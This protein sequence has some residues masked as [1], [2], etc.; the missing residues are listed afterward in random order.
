MRIIENYLNT[1]KTYGFSQ[2]FNTKVFYQE[3]EI[4][5]DNTRVK[6]IHM[7]NKNEE[8]MYPFEMEGL[9]QFVRV[10]WGDDNITRLEKDEIVNSGRY[11]KNGMTIEHT[12]RSA[13]TYRL[14][15]ESVEDLVAVDYNYDYDGNISNS[16]CDNIRLITRKIGGV[17]NTYT[18]PSSE[19]LNKFE[20]D[21]DTITDN[22]IKNN[23]VVNYANSSYCY[24]KNNKDYL[25]PS[26]WCLT[27]QKFDAGMI[28]DLNFRYQLSSNLS[29]F[30]S[31]WNA[32]WEDGNSDNVVVTH[33]ENTLYNIFKYKRYELNLMGFFAHTKGFYHILDGGSI[34]YFV[35]K[36][37][38]DINDYTEYQGSL[39]TNLKFIM[40]DFYEKDDGVK[41]WKIFNG[42]LKYLKL[43]K[44]I[45]KYPDIIKGA[46]GLINNLPYQKYFSFL[47][48]KSRLD[49]KDINSDYIISNPVGKYSLDLSYLFFISS[50]KIQG[51]YNLDEYLI[52]ND[53]CETINLNY[54]KM[55]MGNTFSDNRVAS[56]PIRESIVNS[57][58]ET[59][60]S[61][62]TFLP[63]PSFNN[64][65]EG[66]IKNV[67]IN[68]SKMCY[69]A[70]NQVKMFS[71]NS[72]YSYIMNGYSYLFFSI[73]NNNFLINDL[74][75]IKDSYY[76]IDLSYA[77]FTPNCNYTHG[78]T[79]NTEN[80]KYVIMGLYSNT[81]LKR[82]N[83][84]NKCNITLDENYEGM[85]YSNRM[86]IMKNF[87]PNK[88]Q[89]FINYDFNLK[90]NFI[91]KINYDKLFYN[92]VRVN[93][94]GFIKEDS[95]II[96]R[97]GDTF[98][99]FLSEENRNTFDSKFKCTIS[100][101]YMLFN[102]DYD[103]KEVTLNSLIS[104][105]DYNFDLNN[106][107]PSYTKL[108]VERDE[109]SNLTSLNTIIDNTASKG[110]VNKRFYLNEY[111]SLSSPKIISAASM[112]SNEV[113]Y[114]KQFISQN[115]QI[116]NIAIRDRE[117]Y[118]R[119][120]TKFF[121]AFHESTNLFGLEL[122]DR[123][124]NKNNYAENANLTRMFA[125]NIGL[126]IK[127]TMPYN[128]RMCLELDKY[129]M[130]EMFAIDNDVSFKED[131]EE[132]FKYSE[133]KKWNDVDDPKNVTIKI[134]A[135]HAHIFDHMRI[136]NINNIKIVKNDIFDIFSKLKI[137]GIMKGR[138]LL[139]NF[140]KHLMVYN[141]S[142]QEEYKYF[143]N[144]KVYDYGKYRTRILSKFST[145]LLEK[146]DGLVGA[147][148]VLDRVKTESEEKYFDLDLTPGYLVFVNNI[149]DR[150]LEEK[151]DI[152]AVTDGI[153][154]VLKC[155]FYAVG[156]PNNYEINDLNFIKELINKSITFKLDSEGV[157]N[158][159]TVVIEPGSD[160]ELKQKFT[161]DIKID[162]LSDKYKGDIIFE[163]RVYVDQHSSKAQPIVE[164]KTINQESSIHIQND[165]SV[166][167]GSLSCGDINNVL[168]YINGNKSI[169]LRSSLLDRFAYSN[170]YHSPYN[171]LLYY[172]FVND[173][174]N[175]SVDLSDILVHLDVNS[176]H[177]MLSYSDMFNLLYN[178][179]YM[180]YP[181]LP[182]LRSISTVF[183]LGIIR[184][185]DFKFFSLFK[186]I[187]NYD[188]SSERTRLID[189]E[190]MFNFDFLIDNDVYFV[191]TEE[192]EN[193]KIQNVYGKMNDL[194]LM[195]GSL[196]TPLGSSIYKDGATIPNNKTSSITFNEIF[197][198]GLR[199]PETNTSDIYISSGFLN[200]I[201]NINSHMGII[202]S[203]SIT[204]SFG[205]INNIN[206]KF[207]GN[208]ISKNIISQLTNNFI[209]QKY[210]PN[211]VPPKSL[212][213]L[214]HDDITINFLPGQTPNIKNTIPKPLNIVGDVVKKIV[215]NPIKT[216]RYYDQ[217]NN[218]DINL[219]YMFNEDLP[220]GRI[221]DY[222]DFSILKNNHDVRIRF[223]QTS[224]MFNNCNYDVSNEF[225][226]YYNKMFNI[227]SVMNRHS[228]D[229]VSNEYDQ[230]FMNRFI[231]NR[232]STT[233][234]TIEQLKEIYEENLNYG[235]IITGFKVNKKCKIVYK[236]NSGVDPND[237]ITIEELDMNVLVD[238]N[239]LNVNY[240]KLLLSIKLTVLEDEN[241]DDLLTLDIRTAHRK[242]LKFINYD[243]FKPRIFV[244][245]NNDKIFEM[246]RLRF[247]RKESH[248][249]DEHW[250][251]NISKSNLTRDKTNREVT[252][253]RTYQGEVLFTE[254]LNGIQYILDP[255]YL[256]N[257]SLSF[258][259][260]RD[261]DD[262]VLYCM[263]DTPFSCYNS[264]GEVV[265]IDGNL[266]Y[267]I[268]SYIEKD[269]KGVVNLAEC[270]KE[271]SNTNSV[272]YINPDIFKYS[273]SVLQ[274]EE[275]FYISFGDFSIKDLNL[276]MFNN[277]GDNLAGIYG[278]FNDTN[279]PIENIRGKLERNLKNF[280]IKDSFNLLLSESG[281]S[282]VSPFNRVNLVEITNS[283]NFK[284]NSLNKILPE[285]FLNAS[286]KNKFKVS[287]S[288]NNVTI[289][290]K[291]I[292]ESIDSSR[293]NTI[294]IDSSFRNSVLNT[295]ID[296]YGTN[297]MNYILNYKMSHIPFDIDISKSLETILNEMESL[298]QSL[299]NNYYNKDEKIDIEDGYVNK[300]LYTN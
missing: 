283:F 49:G 107:T 16:P 251:I 121:Y 146:I 181:N 150:K 198:L 295:I 62:I 229:N 131:F 120:I 70:I 130:T 165:H 264:G 35:S 275:P 17:L 204:N 126:D 33:F 206:K 282:T 10:N 192:M 114:I 42:D 151:Y 292:T 18:P 71:F 224:S 216:E 281:I 212:D 24:D 260:P 148:L 242:D 102:C 246:M 232:N 170:F 179:K 60:P 7:F 86:Y 122:S 205:Y 116:N 31:R 29:C 214:Y 285:G 92:T 142:Y 191:R 203:V 235:Q 293:V 38:Y 175:Q 268:L 200:N 173:V 195:M 89:F 73:F 134:G 261:R 132:N 163:S 218:K 266:G 8:E 47:M 78:F 237:I 158:I 40:W 298:K 220:E 180:N 135:K 21:L 227:D 112:C 228:T 53:D 168:N 222:T 111:D 82:N 125:N 27:V 149:L 239:N 129:D 208:F 66:R 54:S 4:T 50:G 115:P 177:E 156:S 9:T 64:S 241:P 270:F 167:F 221:N 6:L 250:F 226:S 139:D 162:K 117:E 249:D 259:I 280:V 5:E 258:P 34:D 248:K 99:D 75:D 76:K 230:L 253:N 79:I 88:M 44:L 106:V 174:I 213:D 30:F 236:V 67:F 269:S 274:T 190:G 93:Y 83:V 11:N 96:Q 263:N 45:R 26:S 104:R 278:S 297:S 217:N 48:L 178:R 272:R 101:N 59:K 262:F 210:S 147:D 300:I 154:C 87:H 243:M 211:Y 207:F 23:K 57:G 290:N 273:N 46:F 1:D 197:N 39:F 37:V 291:L 267:D 186:S 271:L 113:S 124:F 128:D 169:Y 72:V 240:N 234:L 244:K 166:I 157:S 61:S 95:Y 299:S 41:E 28:E 85:C 141:D 56:N 68:A 105:T 103:T 80:S 276:S 110:I 13:G 219:Y 84:I 100:M 15:I 185:N 91:S 140:L 233:E 288:F 137:N 2:S 69:C 159:K 55:F 245:D 238:L 143:I 51:I 74:K 138:V 286:Y 123:I 254:V 196:Y 90:F 77:F 98:L 194:K 187:N 184:D 289:L 171:Y 63:L 94:I 294:E 25:V 109:V 176:Q 257:N 160:E 52:F 223:T 202:N 256:N 296:T 81:Y 252:V 209:H 19:L 225:I 3:I 58:T 20:R 182:S 231:F 145:P 188:I 12:F 193:I 136:F 199:S 215:L 284:T 65:I 119:N 127:Y 279:I 172:K 155:P 255:N 161:Q 201:S 97:V 133:F 287:N 189:S 118:S 164:I 144:N 183:K 265:E 22:H 32:E 36:Y 247:K 43:F 14:K 277:F 108:T 152:S 153:Y